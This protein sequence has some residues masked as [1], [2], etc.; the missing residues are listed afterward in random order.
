MGKPVLARFFEHY[1][2]QL[3]RNDEILVT[4]LKGHLIVEAL[5]VEIIQLKPSNDQPWK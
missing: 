1:I 3:S 5:L 4:L 2:G